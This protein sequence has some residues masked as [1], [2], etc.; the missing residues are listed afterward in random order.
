[1]PAQT[2]L[3]LGG[4]TTGASLT[5]GNDAEKLH[6]WSVFGVHTGIMPGSTLGFVMNYDKHTLGALLDVRLAL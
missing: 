1:M 3:Y 2:G 5:H 6:Y 4:R